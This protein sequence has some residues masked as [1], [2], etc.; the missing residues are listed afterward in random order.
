MPNPKTGTVSMNVEQAV[1]DVKAG[2]VEYRL[3]K[4]ANVHRSHQ[5]GSFSEEQL[6]DNY[7]TLGGNA[8]QSEPAAA[9]GQY[10]K[11]IVVS[12][13]MGPGIRIDTLKPLG[14]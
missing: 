5:Q 13:T 1:K 9:R 7:T 12:T 3:D 11:N 6:L 14:K 2:K 4:A 10:M 8:D